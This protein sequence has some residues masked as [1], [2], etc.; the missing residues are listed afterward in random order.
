MK[1]K[2]AEKFTVFMLVTKFTIRQSRR[3]SLNADFMLES[4]LHLPFVVNLF[5]MF[6]IML[7]IRKFTKGNIEFG[8]L[9]QFFNQISASLVFTGRFIHRIRAV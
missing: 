4:G 2:K 6:C 7:D 5:I 1:L 8:N 9:E 3:F